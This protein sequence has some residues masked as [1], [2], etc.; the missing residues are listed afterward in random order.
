[1][2]MVDGSAWWRL[3]RSPRKKI[4]LL[5]PGCQ[6]VVFN[7]TFNEAWIVSGNHDVEDLLRPT[8]QEDE[9]LPIT[10]YLQT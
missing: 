1:M 7:L 6:R 4:S 2:K 3:V 8:F 9:L 5:H 10:A